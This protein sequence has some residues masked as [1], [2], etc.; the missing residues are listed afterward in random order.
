M[1]S[2]SIVGRDQVIIITWVLRELSSHALATG[3]TTQTTG[4]V[5]AKEQ[6]ALLGLEHGLFSMAR[7]V[8]PP[9]A[10][11]L[12]T[13]V[14]TFWAVAAA[15]GGLDVLLIAILVQA[16]GKNSSNDLKSKSK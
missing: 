7:I 8:G 4:A 11:L 2:S 6:G 12:L 14:G 10:T 5:T 3:L 15:C 16:R 13:Q 1:G 9:L